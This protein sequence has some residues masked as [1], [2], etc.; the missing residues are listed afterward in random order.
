MKKILSQANLELDLVKTANDRTAKFKFNQVSRYRYYS[1]DLEVVGLRVGRE[2]CYR[3]LGNLDLLV[4][5][6]IQLLVG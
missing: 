4:R 5:P 6:L 2:Y 3:N 1:V